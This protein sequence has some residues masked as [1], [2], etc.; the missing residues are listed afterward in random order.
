MVHPATGYQ[1]ATC[2]NFAKDVSEAI[3]ESRKLAPEAAGQ[4][5]LSAMWPK[6][7][8]R[9]WQLYR[10][11]A[12]ALTQM[13]QREIGDFAEAFFS[14]PTES[15]FGFMQGTLSPSQL[16]RVL[17]SVFSHSSTRLKLRLL[18]SSGGG[19][20]SLGRILLAS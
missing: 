1:L 2:L 4:A 15:W 13:N 20:G 7:R 9:A 19:G 8:R 18:R 12:S 5:A 16:L 11:S 6:E 10:W 3:F 14:M 17:A